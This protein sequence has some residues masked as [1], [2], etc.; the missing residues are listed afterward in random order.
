MKQFLFAILSTFVTFFSYS[1]TKPTDCSLFKT[2]NFAYRDS[3]TN[4]I[5]EIKRTKKKQLEKNN[6]TGVVIKQKIRWVSDCEYELT[7]IWSNKK[8]WRK[9]NFRSRIYTIIS[10][11]ENIYSFSC[12]CSDKIKI[13]GTVVKMM[14]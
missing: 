8:E 4:S 12:D 5:W 13:Q 9:G 14:L 1:Q 6:I 10:V 7:Q 2:G 11:S 3:S